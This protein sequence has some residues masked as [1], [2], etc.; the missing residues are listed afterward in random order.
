MPRLSFAP[1]ALHSVLGPLGPL[2]HC[3]V[4]S[5]LQLLQLRV[6]SPAP[7]L[8]GFRYL[9]VVCACCWLQPSQPATGSWAAFQVGMWTSL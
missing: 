9:T 2:R 7:A 5:A 6:R 3:G 8:G 1:Q 4:L